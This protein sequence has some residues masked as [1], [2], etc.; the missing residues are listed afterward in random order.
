MRAEKRSLHGAG[1]EV[2]IELTLPVAELG[3]LPSFFFDPPISPLCGHRGVCASPEIIR[4]QQVI[5]LF[6]K[7]LQPLLRYAGDVPVLE[8][9]LQKL[10]HLEAD[11]TSDR[12]AVPEQVHGLL[13]GL[14]NRFSSTAFQV[15]HCGESR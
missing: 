3:F 15:T 4:I 11:D 14:L 5:L 13:L 12:L 8:H 6:A 7:C 10:Q 9:I 2:E 1:E